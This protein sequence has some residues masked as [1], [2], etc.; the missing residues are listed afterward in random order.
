MWDVVLDA[1]LDTLKL[2][3]FLLLLY[4]LI[5]LM[6]HNTRVGRANAALSGKWAPSSAEQRDLFP[7]ADSPS[8]RQ[9][10]TKSD[11]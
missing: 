8:W 1:L 2:F 11:M 9:S 6:E 10:C 7:C 3:P 5:E 4:I